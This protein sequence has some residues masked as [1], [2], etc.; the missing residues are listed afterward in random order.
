MYVK[1]HK[2]I[3]IKF[4]LQIFNFFT[5]DVNEVMNILSAIDS[6]VYEL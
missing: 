2:D 1:R 3:Q 6:L 5:R 4:N